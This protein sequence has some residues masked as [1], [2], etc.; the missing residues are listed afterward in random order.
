MGNAVKTFDFN[1]ALCRRKRLKTFPAEDI[2]SLITRIALILVNSD[3]SQDIHRSSVRSFKFLNFKGL[4]RVKFRETSCKV[5][6][7]NQE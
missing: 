1:R 2:S 5:V 6:F 3:L 4:N 7:Q